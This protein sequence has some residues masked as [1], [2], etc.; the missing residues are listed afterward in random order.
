MSD[1]SD[2]AY[3]AEWM[4]GLEYSLWDAILHGPQ[5]YGRLSITAEHISALRHLSEACS[6]WIYFDDAKGETWISLLEWE[7]KYNAWRL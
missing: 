3:S 5:K 7:V 2:A 1:L 4:Q 6:G